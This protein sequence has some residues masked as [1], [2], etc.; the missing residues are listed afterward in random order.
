MPFNCF[1]SVG[2]VIAISQIIALIVQAVKDSKGAETEHHQLL[3]ELISL[4]E[5]LDH[6]DSLYSDQRDIGNDGAAKQRPRNQILDLIKFAAVAC[7]Q[8]LEGFLRK[9]QRYNIGSAVRRIQRTF[10]MRND[11]QELQS[12]LHF[13]IGTINMLLAE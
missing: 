7:R 5:S 13:H 1:G 10:M 11:I 4:K 3:S 2:D 12:Y 9:I 6:L 8:P